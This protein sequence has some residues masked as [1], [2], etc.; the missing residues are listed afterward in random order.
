M[1]H[2]AALLAGSWLCVALAAG[3]PVT[4][5]ARS[6]ASQQSQTP[7]FRT[8]VDLV[9]L[10]VSVLDRQ[11]RP[12][13]GLAAAEFRV[14]EDGVLQPVGAFAAI[15]FPDVVAPATPWMREVAAD[16]TTNE[17]E[18]RRVFVLVLDDAVA[19]SDPWAT[20][21]VID[22]ATAIIEQ[23]GPTDLASV[24]FTRD[25]RQSQDLT[26]DRARLL[27]AVNTFSRLGSVNMGC[28]YPVMSL[29]VLERLPTYLA[30]IPE[31]RKAVVYLSPGV[32]IPSPMARDDCNLNSRFRD[33]IT[34]AQRANV[35]FYPIDVCGLAPV[36]LA[37]QGLSCR[38]APAMLQE[39]A[40]NTGGRAVVRT[41][42]FAPG[43]QQMFREN[44]SYYLLGYSPTNARA[45]GTIRRIEVQVD[46]PDVDVWT[47]KQYVAPKPPPPPGAKATPPPAAVQALA[48]IVPKPDLPLRVA[49]APFAVPGRPAAVTIALG[50][51]QP[52]QGDRFTDEV[53]LL[54]KA[55][56]PEGVHALRRARQ[57]GPEAGALRASPVGAQRRGRQG[58]Q[59]VR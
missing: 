10:D 3:A 30:A 39:L 57:A 25:N 24:I 37:P 22:S 15:D 12:I 45:D 29:S 56:T 11:R 47:R 43:I 55:Y 19:A 7:V 9:Q 46:R 14:Y 33:A 51:R 41:N 23:L 48:E 27:K 13:R 53:K 18:N 16:V 34:N 35:N 21:A 42:D 38:H 6:P 17:I 28:T 31:R 20:R 32:G 36:S 4:R 8:G 5:A 44:S 50:L 1:N 40:D 49:V 2:H 58:R 52:W 26:T 54:V 59:R